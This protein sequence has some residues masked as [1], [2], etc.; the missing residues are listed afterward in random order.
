MV[1]KEKERMLHINF[2]CPKAVI[3][4]FKSVV[5]AGYFPNISEAYR[6]AL[7]EY[8][9]HSPTIRELM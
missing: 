5:D 4:M 3:G 1:V 6:H 7:I 2:Y 8:V 9:M